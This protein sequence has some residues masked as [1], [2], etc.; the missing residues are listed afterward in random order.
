[1]SYLASGN[2]AKECFFFLSDI[3][4]MLKAICSIW[5]DNIF[6]KGNQV[7]KIKSLVKFYLGFNGNNI[8]NNLK[9]TPKIT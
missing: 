8:L 9:F 7:D 3:G 6:W 1:M 4:L 5:Y 2:K